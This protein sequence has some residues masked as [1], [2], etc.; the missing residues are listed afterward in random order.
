MVFSMPDKSNSSAISSNSSSESDI[1]AS[2]SI[3]GG[4]QIG[5]VTLR[6]QAMFAVII[7][8]LATK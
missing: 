8:Y 1:G 4:S 5:T 3:T 7:F 2:Q 6:S